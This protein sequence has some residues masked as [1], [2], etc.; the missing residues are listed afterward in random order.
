M[1]ECLPE[2]DP[3]SHLY[4]NSISPL[5]KAISPCPLGLKYRLN[6]NDTWSFISIPDLSIKLQT[7]LSN[8]L[9]DIFTWITNGYHKLSMAKPQIL[10]ALQ[11]SS[12]SSLT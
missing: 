2:S 3:S 7:Q 12:Y 9:N 5:E 8:F 11:I 10:V 6:V 4:T 1:L